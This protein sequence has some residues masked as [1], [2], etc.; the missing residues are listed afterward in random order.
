[1]IGKFRLSK[2]RGKWIRERQQDHT[3][4]GRPLNHPAVIESQFTKQSIQ[5]VDS[6]LAETQRVVKKLFTSKR[7][8]E[9][10]EQFV[11][12]KSFSFESAQDAESFTVYVNR[13]LD[14]MTARLLRKVDTHGKRVARQMIKG[15]NDDS[16]RNVATSLKELSGGV[17]IETSAL[18]GP[19][20][21]MMQASIASNVELIVSINASYL[22]KITDAVNRSILE[23]RGLADL[24][25]FME[26]QRGITKRHAKNVA[27]D[28]T[29]KA[30]N[31]LNVVRMREVGLS[32][33]RWL[34]SGGGQRPRELHITNYPAGL[35]G[36]IYDVNDPPLIQENPPVYGLPAFLPFCKCRMVP[37][38]IVEKG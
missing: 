38:L 1:M 36:G 8:R 15:V 14:R 16:Q 27:L 30:Y 31:S 17:T 33:F 6:V 37:L 28:Q 23:G 9:Y 13:I 7:G 32:K 25:P 3:F 18:G 2:Q 24:V 26:K 21:E 34:H 19:I 11:A 22:G 35:N 10:F 12:S 5:I 20:V 29:R 4:Q